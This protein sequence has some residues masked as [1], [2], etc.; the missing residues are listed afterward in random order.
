MSNIQNV[1]SNDSLAVQ[2]RTARTPRYQTPAT[3]ILEN[4]SEYLLLADMPG[5]KP[6]DV[7]IELSQNQL[8]IEAKREGFHGVPVAYRR[9][10][11]VGTGV[12]PN[13]IS[14]ELKQGVLHLVAKKSDALKPRQITVNAG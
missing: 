4:E 5:V 1:T 14:A 9:V 11:Q 2:E 12:D 10:F 6:D 8:T 3:D 13:G 7:S